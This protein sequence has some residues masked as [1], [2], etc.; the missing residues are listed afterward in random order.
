MRYFPLEPPGITFHMT[1]ELSVV[2]PLRMARQQNIPQAFHE[3]VQ[4]TTVPDIV[5]AHKAFSMEGLK[6]FR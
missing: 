4:H 3:L 5:T 6:G 2:G 1:F